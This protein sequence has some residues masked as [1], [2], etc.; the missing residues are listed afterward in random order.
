MNF[1][2]S[3]FL[4]AGRGY[5]ALLNLNKMKDINGLIKKKK[6]PYFNNCLQFTD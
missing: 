4:L 6:E 3:S 5:G 2:S 1:I